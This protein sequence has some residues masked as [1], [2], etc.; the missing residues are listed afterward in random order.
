MIYFEKEIK[1]MNHNWFALTHNMLWDLGSHQSRG[2]ADD[3]A[4]DQFNIHQ[5]SGGYLILLHA[6]FGS[7]SRNFQKHYVEEQVS[8]G[9]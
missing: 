2:A 9:F 7:L 5:A 6:E 3:Y 1:T 4:V 8:K